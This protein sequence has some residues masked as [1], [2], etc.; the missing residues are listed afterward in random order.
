MDNV[1]RLMRKFDSLKV[2]QELE[3]AGVKKGDLV[4]IYG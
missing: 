3:K 4:D 1:S 2:N